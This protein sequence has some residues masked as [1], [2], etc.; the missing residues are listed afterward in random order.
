MRARFGTLLP[1]ETGWQSVKLVSR[2]ESTG[3]CVFRTFQQIV[4]KSLRGEVGVLDSVP[5]LDR[6]LCVR[7]L[8]CV[9]MC[10]CVLRRR[11]A[12]F[13]TVHFRT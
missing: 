4:A 11:V 1:G 12:Q 6:A 13:G 9:R 3:G 8:A 10:V 7:A 5:E 2:C